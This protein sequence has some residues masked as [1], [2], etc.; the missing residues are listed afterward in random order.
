MTWVISL[1][2]YVSGWVTLNPKDVAQHLFSDLVGTPDI[3]AWMEKVTKL[4]GEGG[5]LA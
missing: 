1:G 4:H 5:E 2:L 3:L